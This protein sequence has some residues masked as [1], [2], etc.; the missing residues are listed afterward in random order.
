MSSEVKP[1]SVSRDRSAPAAITRAAAIRSETRTMPSIA[2]LRWQNER[3]NR[4]ADIESHCAATFA[5]AAPIPFLAEENMRG[6][7]MLLSG[8]FQGFCRD[9]YTE[10]AQVFASTSAAVLQAAI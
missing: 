1:S 7:A 4:L 2:L 9:L 5:L 3:M 6:Y 10:C 8:H